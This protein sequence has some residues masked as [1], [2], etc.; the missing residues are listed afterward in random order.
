MDQKKVGMKTTRISTL[1]VSSNRHCVTCANGS[2]CTDFNKNK[3][4]LCGFHITMIFQ[5]PT[6]FKV[7]PKDEFKINII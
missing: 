1:D 4:G 2:T 5:Q 3:N 7:K 6:D